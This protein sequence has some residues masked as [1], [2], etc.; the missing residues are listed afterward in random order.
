MNGLVMLK[1]HV[2]DTEDLIN[3]ELDNR[4]GSSGPDHAGA[5]ECT[6]GVCCLLGVLQWAQDLAGGQGRVNRETPNLSERAPLILVCAA[7]HSDGCRR[8]VPYAS[9]ASH[10]S[11]ASAFDTSLLSAAAHS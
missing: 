1:E 11:S 9:H 4:C 7:L 6:G 10:G 5:L 2:D 8:K 3:I